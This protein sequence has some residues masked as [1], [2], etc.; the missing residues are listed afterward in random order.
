M[1]LPAVEQ[2]L[3]RILGRPGW[4]GSL[5]G[6]QG[7]KDSA[8]VPHPLAVKPDPRAS[9]RLLASRASSWSLAA[10]PRDPRVCLRSMVVGLGME[11]LCF[12]TQLVMQLECPKSWVGLL[13]A[14]LGP[15]LS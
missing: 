9:D 12:P 1:L 8:A 6:S 14:G 7:H 13:E 10:G 11:G 15:S 2:D 4:A 5:V 3:V